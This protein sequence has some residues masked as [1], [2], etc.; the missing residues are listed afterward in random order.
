MR[1]PIRPRRV[2]GKR[3]ARGPRRRRRPEAPF[4]ARARRRARTTPHLGRGDPVRQRPSPGHRGRSPSARRGCLAGR[5][6]SFGGA[7]RGRVAAISAGATVPRRG[8]ERRGGGSVVIVSGSAPDSSRAPWT[9]G[10]GTSLLGAASG[11]ADDGVSL[12]A[13]AGGRAGPHPTTNANETMGTK[14]ARTAPIDTGATGILGTRA[15]V[16][17]IASRSPRCT[18]PSSTENPRPKPRAPSA[19]AWK[20]KAPCRPPRRPR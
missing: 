18:S 13:D 4:E 19:I 5:T 1:R 10:A 15:G 20:P 16:V 8:V 12:G 3:G 2:S 14:G 11:V 9:C 17:R 6:P 7:R